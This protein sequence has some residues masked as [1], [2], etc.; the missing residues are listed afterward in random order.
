LTVY[1]GKPTVGNGHPGR[2]CDGRPRQ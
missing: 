1:K 2:V